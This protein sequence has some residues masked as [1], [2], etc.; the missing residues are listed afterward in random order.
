MIVLPV[1]VV[2]C[3]GTVV[4]TG[5]RAPAIL[6][7]LR[8]PSAQASKLLGDRSSVSA[9]VAPNFTGGTPGSVGSIGP[10]TQSLIVWPLGARLAC[11]SAAVVAK[12]SVPRI[13]A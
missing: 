13:F 2:P 1:T 9:M 12:V 5:G 10:I 7:W 8:N 6:I 11:Q 4:M 3:A